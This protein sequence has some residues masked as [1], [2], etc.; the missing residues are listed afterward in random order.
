MGI[1]PLYVVCIS[2]KKGRGNPVGVGNSFSVTCEL[3]A[4]CIEFSCTVLTMS[5]REIVIICS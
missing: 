1:L 4:F 2:M 5:N 3:G